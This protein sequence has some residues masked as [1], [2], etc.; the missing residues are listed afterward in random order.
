[1]NAPIDRFARGENRAMTD[2]Q[3]RGALIFFGKANCVQCHAVAG[4]SNKLFSDFENHVAGIPQI[5][6]RFG[7]GLGNVPFRNRKG[8][9]T[10]D[11]SRSSR[12]R[13]E[14]SNI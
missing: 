12:Q 14:R 10:D 7:A 2:A 11:D 6:A 8:Q 13:I 3:K 4:G 5:A 9:F 1:M